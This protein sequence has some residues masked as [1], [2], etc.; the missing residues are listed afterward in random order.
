M[1][2]VLQY[3]STNGAK[4]GYIILGVYKQV[5]M[6]HARR[7]LLRFRVNC[8]QTPRRMFKAILYSLVN[9]PLPLCWR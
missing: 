7:A 1:G 9:L 5:G 4:A 8:I 6:P 2:V 3:Y